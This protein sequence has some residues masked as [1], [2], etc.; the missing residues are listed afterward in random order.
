MDADYKNPK[1]DWNYW[2]NRAH[3]SLWDACALSLQIDPESFNWDHTRYGS[4]PGGPMYRSGSQATEDQQETLAEHRKRLTLL[5]QNLRNQ[6]F[7]SPP[8][9]DMVYDN[10]VR[11]PEFSAWFQTLER[12]PPLPPELDQLTA[13]KV[14]QSE[15]ANVAEAII[16][17][18]QPEWVRA[19]IASADRIAAERYGHGMQEISARYIAAPVAAELSKVSAYHTNNRGP[20]SEGNIRNVA[21]K[22]WKFKP[23]AAGTTGTIGTA[24]GTTASSP[25]HV[26]GKHLQ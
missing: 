12:S 11:L 24:T 7:F 21:L 4:G 3:V 22:G 23:S 14:N 26:V 2:I 17:T 1:I 5:S 8:S 20:R 18:A 13:P 10:D 15:A 6:Q 25:E 16:P 9:A 19:A